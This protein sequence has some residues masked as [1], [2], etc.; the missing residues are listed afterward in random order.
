MARRLPALLASFSVAAAITWTGL[1]GARGLDDSAPVVA[2]QLA[3]ARAQRPLV[4]TEHGP[5]EL[6]DW[7]ETIASRLEALPASTRERGSDR[8]IA[9]AVDEIAAASGGRVAIEVRELDTGRVL[10]AHS[11]ERALNPASN[12]KLI[13]AIAAV[14]LLGPDYRFET[15]LW[16]AGDALI[17]RGEGDPDLHLHDLHEL[18]ADAHAAG[19]L[20]GV[21]TILVDDTA[22]DA[23]TLGPGF[24][25]DGPGESYVAPSGALA[26]DYGT[27]EISVAPGRYRGPARVGAR[28]GSEALEIHNAAQTRAGQLQVRTRPGSEGRTIVE[29]DGAIAG[30]HAPILVRRRVAD[31]GVFAGATLAS[32]VAARLG[33]D[34]L[35]VD[36]AELPA[37][38]E[39]V[40]VHRSKP[41]VAVLSSALR[42][43]NNFTAEQ[44]LRTLAWRAAAR[45]GA[46]SDGAA[47]LERFARAVS[48]ERAGE[49]RFVNGSG[50]TREGRLSP[51]FVIDVLALADRPGSPAAL[52]LASFA[53]A[54][55]EGTLRARLGGAGSRVLAKTG[56]YAG[57]SSLSGVVRDAEG[58]H[59]LGFS[60]LCN[61]GR[62]EDNRGL[63]DQL[64]AA[65]L[66]R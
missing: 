38:A 54:G 23:R 33:R 6:R 1:A 12:Q 24:R 21:E 59:P 32:L 35:R 47:T 62:L 43:S 45:P 8:R 20:A 66:R 29:V 51:A 17:V 18:V 58:E 65:L 39:L 34:S 16:R 57:A 42:Y 10:G 50:L 30:G 36:R 49:Q 26:I 52:L 2:P 5:R 14:E 7:S 63:Q 27:V 11:A 41:L 25:S 55:G 3:P 53:K 9:A 64:V 13:T 46:W 37:D 19:A 28:V 15:S 31:P 40:A 60:I 48:P 4:Q 44:V 56:T 61:G 22:F